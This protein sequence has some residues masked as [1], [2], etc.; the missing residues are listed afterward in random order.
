MTQGTAHV[1]I[2]YC[3]ILEGLFYRR[4]MYKYTYV[5]V[6]CLFTH[7]IMFQM[8]E[9]P[10]QA[11][12]TEPKALTSKHIENKFRKRS[13]SIGAEGLSNRKDQRSKR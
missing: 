3:D 4:H 2:L 8:S 7:D 13:M 5:Y 9:P 11:F 1:T 12:E 6:T 10:V